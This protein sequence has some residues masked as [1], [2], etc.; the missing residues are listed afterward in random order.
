[1]NLIKHKHIDRLI[2][3]T[4][5]TLALIPNLM[6]NNEKKEL[7]YKRNKLLEKEAKN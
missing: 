2:I 7:K 3:R 5:K 6:R 1:M 4:I